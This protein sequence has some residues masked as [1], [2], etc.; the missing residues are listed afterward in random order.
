MLDTE[1]L[2]PEE[3]DMLALVERVRVRVMKFAYVLL[4]C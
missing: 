4:V 2:L 1:P 3:S